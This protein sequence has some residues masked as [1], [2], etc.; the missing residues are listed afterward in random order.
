[1]G[2]VI[3][4]KNQLS[5]GQYAMEGFDFDEAE[6]LAIDLSETY[7]MTA[8]SEVD[9]PALRKNSSRLNLAAE[10]AEQNHFMH[11]ELEFADLFKERGGFDLVVGNPP[12]IKIEWKV[13][14][15]LSEFVP[16]IA[17]QKDNKKAHIDC[18]VSA[19]P[20]ILTSEYVTTAGQL[21][22]LSASSNYLELSGQY[23]NIYKNFVVQ[24]DRYL[25]AQG[26]Y[27]L[28]HPEGLYDNPNGESFRQYLFK[29]LR[30]HFEFIN[31]RYLF[32]DVAH[33]KRFSINVAGKKETKSF[34]TITNLFATSSVDE[35]FDP[36][37]TNALMGL[38]D[39]N[40]EWN[41]YGH[42]R[43]KIVVDSSTLRLFG[44]IFD[45]KESLG[46]RMP[47][48]HADICVDFFKV[49]SQNTKTIGDANGLYCTQLMNETAAIKNKL[50]ETAVSYPSNM[51]EFVYSG[52]NIWVGNPYFKSAKYPCIE[53]SDY[54]L[55]DLKRINTQGFLPRSKYKTTEKCYREL[56][57]L[58]NGDLYNVPYKIFARRRLNLSMERT[59]I[60]AIVPK[61][62]VQI[63]A[64]LGISMN[65]LKDLVA[66]AGCL[67]TIVYDFYIKVYGKE[68]L[69]EN[70]LAN[71]PVPVSEECLSQIRARVLCL[72]AIGQ[73][74][75]ELWAKVW[76]ESFTQTCWSKND[77]RLPKEL[78]MTSRTWNSSYIATTDYAR[79]QLLVELDTLVAYSLGMSLPLLVSIYRMQFPVL[80]Q[81][82]EDTWYDAEG[83]IVFTNNKGLS[84]VGFPRTEWENGIKGAPAGQK[85]YRTIMDDTMPGGPVERTIEYV[86]PF[87]RCDREQDYET[88]WKFFEEKYAKIE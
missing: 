86:A 75:E 40:N 47:E 79:R 64:V 35:C 65:D 62:T 68:D 4:T 37:C 24:A 1:M 61:D 53:K 22:F 73:Q 23:G 88:A 82:E 55:V 13:E 43:R 11:W 71:L 78:F 32:H 25:D 69:Y 51:G 77:V 45:G 80:R 8:D 38:K 70:T 52:P 42:S 31:E 36:N 39:S 30:Y 63:H 81:Y 5:T 76:D 46:A 84:N 26:I 83:K 67:N 29:H 59:L 16:L 18:A 6:Q 27:G 15:L 33:T 74:F 20:K 28:V 7:A 41:V 66:I 34:I 49:M 10:I 60:S 12:W 87:D 2:S 9:I 19:Y 57:Y 44:K 72:N 3:G 50:V 48:V 85:F 54:D 17:I 21:S 14:D 58:P 56:P